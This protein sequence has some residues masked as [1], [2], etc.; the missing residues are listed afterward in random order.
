MEVGEDL[1]EKA[2]PVGLMRSGGV[3]GRCRRWLGSR[4]DNLPI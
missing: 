4:T 1:E 3:F 2:V